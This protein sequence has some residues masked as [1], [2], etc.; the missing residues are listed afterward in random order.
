MRC[1]RTACCVPISNCVETGRANPITQRKCVNYLL[2]E[3]KQ[4]QKLF[5][6]SHQ[7]R[8]HYLALLHAASLGEDH[9]G[10]NAPKCHA[11]MANYETSKLQGGGLASFGPDGVLN[12]N[13]ALYVAA[14][15]A[16][17]CSAS[18]DWSGSKPNIGSHSTTIS[19][20]VSFT[21]TC[22]RARHPA[23]FFRPISVKCWMRAA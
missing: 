23:G 11:P 2:V 13:H 6:F 5:N 21:L 20:S 19:Y 12:P 16:V 1:G 14:M 10:K 7:G 3:L 15:N 8:G 22:R 4:W 9:P 17:S 18:G